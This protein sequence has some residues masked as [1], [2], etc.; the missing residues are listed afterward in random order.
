MLWCK[1]LSFSINGHNIAHWQ[2][3]QMAGTESS[4]SAAC[5]WDGGSPDQ[6]LNHR[7]L[8]K[9]TW[10]RSRRRAPFNH[11]SRFN[12]VFHPL[13]SPVI[14]RLRAQVSLFMWSA[15]E[16]E[17]YSCDYFP[18][19]RFLLRIL[20]QMLPIG[21][22]ITVWCSLNIQYLHWHCQLWIWYLLWC[23]IE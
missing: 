10:Q 19:L 2:G 7:K 3:W 6:Q 15:T 16:L 17:W 8:S 22:W 9:V 13:D 20:W 5:V 14:P 1:F 23:L 18:C 12:F 21:R 11:L 4:S